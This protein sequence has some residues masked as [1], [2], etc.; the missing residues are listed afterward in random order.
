M[1]FK[2]LLLATFFTLLAQPTTTLSNDRTFAILVKSTLDRNF[3][4][5]AHG[6]NEVAARDNDRCILLGPASPS[7]PRRQLDQLERALK[8]YRFDALAISV[9]HSGLLAPTLKRLNVPIITFDSPLATEYEHLAHSYIGINNF[10][11]GYEM[12]LWVQRRHPQG[13]TVCLMTAQ[14]TNLDLRMLGVR[15]ALSG[16]RDWPPAQRLEGES[17]WTEPQRCPWDAGDDADRALRQLSFTL[18][19]IKPTAFVAVGHWPLVKPQDYRQTITP[20]KN[21]APASPGTSSTDIIIATGTLGETEQQLLAD[22][23]VNAISPIDFTELGR[24]LARQLQEVALG[25]WLPRRIL[26]P[27]QIHAATSPVAPPVA[28]GDTKTKALP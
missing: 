15:A 17:G 26:F 8:T 2:L 19:H 11:F 27:T 6:C 20:F 5:A 12:G 21:A 7:H 10:D 4:A 16:S 18:T 13:G 9:T 3:I 1:H 14:D 24:T 23:L 28:G 22:G 25:H